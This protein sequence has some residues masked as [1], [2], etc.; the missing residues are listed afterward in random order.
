MGMKERHER[1][2][3]IRAKEREER[4]QAE[5]QKREELIALSRQHF[6]EI[7]GPITLG[8]PGWKCRWDFLPDSGQTP[9]TFI[10]ADGREWKLLK[11]I[12]CMFGTRIEQGRLAEVK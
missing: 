12:E 2:A 4:G 9:K 6:G 8:F 7:T 1:E 11:D 5:G 10:A 3:E